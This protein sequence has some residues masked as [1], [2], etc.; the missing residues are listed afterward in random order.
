MFFRGV[1]VI[2]VHMSCSGHPNTV[3]V[4]RFSHTSHTV[5]SDVQVSSHYLQKTFRLSRVCDKPGMGPER[6]PTSAHTHT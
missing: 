4:C 5:A 3:V 6:A 1:P 2:L